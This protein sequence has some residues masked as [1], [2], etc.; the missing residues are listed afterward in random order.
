M[1]SHR[2]LCVEMYGIESTFLKIFELKIQKAI[3]EV[4]SLQLELDKEDVINDPVYFLAR[5]QST[6]VLVEEQ[7]RY[8]SYYK[9][10]HATGNMEKIYHK[11][12]ELYTE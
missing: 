9:H 5:L 10:C 7:Y 2:A 4:K 8:I 6:I 1:T 12:T 3:E 11:A